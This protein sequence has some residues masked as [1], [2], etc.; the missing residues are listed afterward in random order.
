MSVEN[1][2][3]DKLLPDQ[4]TRINRN[5]LSEFELDELRENIDHISVNIEKAYRQAKDRSRKEY[6]Q[7][8]Y[9]LGKK[10]HYSYKKEKLKS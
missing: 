2:W 4:L 5:K 6:N 1:D 10:L 9:S 7:A 3:D 8:K